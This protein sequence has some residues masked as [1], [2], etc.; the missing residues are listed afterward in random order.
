M[1]KSHYPTP[2]PG[3]A[4]YKPF[5]Q[6]P[7]GTM[8]PS[9]LE[10]ALNSILYPRLGRQLVPNDALPYQRVRAVAVNTLF[11]KLPFGHG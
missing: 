2:N 11:A 10:P 6:L 4:F 5:T 1:A 8:G 9:M 3:Q 7:D